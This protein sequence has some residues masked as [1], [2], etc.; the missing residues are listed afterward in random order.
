MSSNRNKFRLLPLFRQAVP[1]W[2]CLVVCFFSTFLTFILI[3]RNHEQEKVQQQLRHY[4]SVYQQNNPAALQLSYAADRDN[5]N[6]FLRLEGPDIRLIL[7]TKD[8]SGKAV[9][10]PDFSSF[11]VSIDLIWHALQPGQTRGAWT[12]GAVSLPDGNTLQIGIDSSESLLLVRNMGITL[13]KL[14]IFLLPFCCIP[15]WFTVRSHSAAIRKLT[16][17]INAMSADN[18]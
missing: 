3:L 7:V 16:A 12:V 8:N 13:L 5:S 10:L 11:P 17:Q 2:I 6:S 15:A 1:C 14:V 4:Q 18:V 9:P